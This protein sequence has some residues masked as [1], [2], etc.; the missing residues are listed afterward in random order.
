MMPLMLLFPVV[1]F[2]RVYFHCHWVFDTVMGS[3]VGLSFASFSYHIFP[4][5]A[6]LFSHAYWH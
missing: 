4:Y 5:Y 3:I 1:A 6:S 2:A